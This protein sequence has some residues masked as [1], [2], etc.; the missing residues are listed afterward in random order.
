[1]NDPRAVSRLWTSVCLAAL[2]CGC[3]GATYV[4]HR[5]VNDTSDTLKLGYRSD[6]AASGWTTDTV[7]TLLPGETRVHHAVDFWGKC[8]DCSAYEQLPYGID[9]L[10]VEGRV[11]TVDLMNDSLWRVQVDEG[12]TWIRFEQE[13][14]V[15]PSHF[16]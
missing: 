7:W 12:L 5:L 6:E 1:M 2:L 10:W 11:L 16:D 14:T 4:D 15:V 13:L 3:E 9:T 8:H